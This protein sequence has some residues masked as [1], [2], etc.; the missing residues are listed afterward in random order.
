MVDMMITTQFQVSDFLPS[1]EVQEELQHISVSSQQV[2]ATLL[3]REL[4]F[5]IN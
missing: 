4:F 3:E 5:M 1:P 2:I